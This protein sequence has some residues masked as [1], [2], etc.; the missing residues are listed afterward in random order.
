MNDVKNDASGKNADPSPSSASRPAGS[1]PEQAGR[2][3][4]AAAPASRPGDMNI[5][6]NSDKKTDKNGDRNGQR[7][8]GKSAA[9]PPDKVADKAADKPR[10][11]EPGVQSATTGRPRAAFV[12][13]SLQ[14]V[15][16][17]D[18]EA[19]ALGIT[20]DLRPLAGFASYVD[21]RLCGRVSELLRK[22]T[23]TGAA[24][25]KVLMP[26]LGMIPARRIFL[27]GWGPR[28]SLLDGA[29]ERFAWMVDVL[30]QAGVERVAVA[31]PEPAAMLLG[32]VDEHLRKPLGDKCAVVFAPDQWLVEPRD[33]RPIPAP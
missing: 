11:A 12:E 29:T 8:S 6:K 32:L 1:A 33:T 21:W 18:C 10:I 17:L 30:L 3:D 4:T 19:I 2:G 13:P 31:L 24:R 28:A 23:L 26:T 7:P 22:G 25:E 20:S 16:A 27:F 5:D 14:A 9:R 15:D